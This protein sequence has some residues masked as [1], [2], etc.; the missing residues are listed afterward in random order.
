MHEVLFFVISKQDTVD[1]GL[2]QPSPLLEEYHLRN[3]DEESAGTFS[4][5]QGFTENS[6]FFEE[7]EVT[8]WILLLFYYICGLV[9]LSLGML[10]KIMPSYM[11]SCKLTYFFE[12]L[13]N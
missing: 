4:Y 1:Q 10:L 6:Q 12:T 2:E 9:I 7:K 3:K 5:S 13:G 11:R 8:V